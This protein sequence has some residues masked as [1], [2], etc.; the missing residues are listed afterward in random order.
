MNKEI[1]ELCER[2]AIDHECEIEE[3]CIINAVVIEDEKLKEEI[4]KLKKERDYYENQSIEMANIADQ[5]INEKLKAQEELET[6]KRD[7]IES[8]AKLGE[9]R[10]KLGD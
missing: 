4:Q 6:W 2:Y 5:V 1:C 7:A 9:I 3:K 8:K 10:I